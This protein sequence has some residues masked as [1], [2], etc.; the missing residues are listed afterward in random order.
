MNTIKSNLTDC[1]NGCKQFF[2]FIFSNKLCSP[3]VL[4]CLHVFCEAC[5]DKLMVNEAGDSLKF[6]LAVECPICKQETKVD[7]NSVLHKLIF[8]FYNFI[9]THLTCVYFVIRYLEV[10]L[11]PFLLIMCLPTFW[12]FL[13]W[14]NLLFALVAR[15]R[16][17]LLLDALIALIFCV[18]TAIQLTNL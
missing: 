15:A 6:D 16:N 3:R 8:L 18:P 11:H 9:G 13:P 1:H 17:L 4:S 7:R 10:G 14:I 2:F 5:I 12:M